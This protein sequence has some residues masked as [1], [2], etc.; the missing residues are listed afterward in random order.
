MN[1]LGRIQPALIPKMNSFVVPDVGSA[2]YITTS[3]EVFASER[4]VRFYEMEYAVPRKNGIEAFRKVRALIDTLD[5]PIS[6]PIEVRVLGADDIPLSTASGQETIYIAVHVFFG[7]PYE[8]YFQGVESIMDELGGRPH[9]G[10]LH[11]QT[12]ETLSKKYPKWEL[13]QEVRYQLD[14]TGRFMN[15]EL[16]K[17]LGK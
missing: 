11:F 7:T 4:R 13:F 5:H 17:V 2:S 14:P 12:S 3:Y 9:W 8:E 6:F 10:K 16:L 15:D 1:Y